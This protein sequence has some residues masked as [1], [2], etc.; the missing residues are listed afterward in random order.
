M[1]Y[2]SATWWMGVF[3]KHF[4]SVAFS[5]LLGLA[6]TGIA[7]D[8]P[9]DLD[10]AT[11]IRDQG[12]YHS[13]VMDLAWH[14]TEGVGP[15]LTGTPQSLIAHRWAESKFAEWGLKSWL[16]DFEFGRSWA[17]ERAQVRILEPFD[18]PLEAL[19]EA[20]SP[21]TDGAVRGMAVRATLESQ[22]DLETWQGKLAGAIVLLDEATTVNQVDAGLFERWDEAGLEELVQY[23]IP[24][25]RSGEWRQRMLKRYTF[26]KQLSAFLQEEGVIATLEPSSR[27]N[28]IVR[29]TGNSSN[30]EGELPTGVPALVMATEQYNLLVRL[31]DNDV[32][33]EL[34]IDVAVRWFE[35][36]GK[37]YNTLADL[38]GSDLA[39]QTVVVGAHL[40]SWHAATGA[41]DNGANC[42]VVMEALRILKDAGLKPRRTIRA[43]LWTGEEQGLL[44][45]KDYVARYLATRPETTDPEQLE[46]PAW[47]RETTWPIQPLP[48]YTTISG[49]FNI[50]NGAG[51]I[52]GIYAQENAAVVPIFSAWLEPFAD[53]GA[54]TVTMENTSSTD[55]MSFDRVGIPGF[56]FVQDRMDYMGRT[57]HSNVDTFDH[58]NPEDMKQSAVVLAWFIWQAANRDELLPRKPMPTKPEEPASN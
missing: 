13:Q 3:M 28:G 33:P 35:D 31:L 18:Q 40:D 26:R 32:E 5:L 22:E 23:D 7:G 11:K 56:Q 52:R 44:G 10:A 17:V 49:Y 37:A 47:A 43:A 21:G 6:A 15:R 1:R 29:V 34:E 58:L 48:G 41:T 51:R 46:L 53:L 14:L 25:G 20:W 30:R 19:P 9:V 12:F 39:T 54:D 45:S 36:D 4:V 42:A 24:D 8:E 55:H 27:D 16:E 50:D 2:N 57:H 38:E